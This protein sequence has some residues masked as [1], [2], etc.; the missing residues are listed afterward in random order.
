MYRYT[1]R[2]PREWPGSIP[3]AVSIFSRNRRGHTW[4]D[5][6]SLLLDQALF[7]M[8]GGV[9]F[10]TRPGEQWTVRRDAYQKVRDAFE[11]NGIRRAERNVK[12]E[13]A[14]DERLSEDERKAVTAAAQ[15]A[16]AQPVKPGIIPDEP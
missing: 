5:S 4:N 14:G 10:M 11:A 3:L 2:W 15:E 13:I 8:V 6:S 12:V 16:V 9:K 1:G 7:N